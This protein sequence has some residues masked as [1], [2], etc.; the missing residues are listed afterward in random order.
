M[1]ISNNGKFIAIGSEN[2]YLMII[3]IQREKTVYQISSGACELNCLQ[4]LNN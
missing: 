1:A 2:D 4:I 3:D